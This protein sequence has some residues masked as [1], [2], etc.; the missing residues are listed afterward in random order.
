MVSYANAKAIIVRY[1]NGHCKEQDVFT[2]SGN[3]NAHAHCGKGTSP[4]P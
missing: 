1:D 2:P 3:V 4:P